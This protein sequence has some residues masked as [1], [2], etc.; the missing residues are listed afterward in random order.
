MKTKIL[1]ISILLIGFFSKTEAQFMLTAKGG[2][3]FNN[4]I[5]SFGLI[6]EVTTKSDNH[7]FIPAGIDLKLRKYKVLNPGI[8]IEYL[9]RSFSTDVTS[10]YDINSNRE[11]T[12]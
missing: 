4:F 11:K 3:G 5:S 7:Y 1:I 6:K 2:V 10:K 12:I 8:S 9:S